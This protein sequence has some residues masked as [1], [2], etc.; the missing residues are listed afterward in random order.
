MK[1]T[2]TLAAAL[3]LLSGIA[4]KVVKD[5]ERQRRMGKTPVFNPDH[6]PELRGQL[7]PGVWDKTSSPR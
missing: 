3:L 2:I 5:Y 4:V 7:E 6:F 1:T